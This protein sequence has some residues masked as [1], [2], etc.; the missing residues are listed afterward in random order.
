MLNM[1]STKLADTPPPAPLI[2]LT[3]SP[4]F[5][6]AVTVVVA[7]KVPSASYNLTVLSAAD[8]ES[9]IP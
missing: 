8:I 5:V 3:K 7:S 9:V 6:A 1:P 2:K 4:I